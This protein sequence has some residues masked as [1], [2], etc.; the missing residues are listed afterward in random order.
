MLIKHVKI[1]LLLT[2]HDGSRH[3]GGKSFKTLKRNI[4]QSRSP[5][6]GKDGISLPSSLSSQCGP[7]LYGTPSVPLLRL[8][9]RLH[10]NFGS[11]VGIQVFGWTDSTITLFT[12]WGTLDFPLFFF[13]SAVLLRKSLRLS[14]VKR[15]D[16]VLNPGVRHPLHG[17]GSVH[18]MSASPISSPELVVH[19]LLPCW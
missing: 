18:P 4:R 14:V 17:G 9:R 10:L 3:K 13:P 5:S 7:A 8:R 2:V 12:L 15:P 16:F 1:T 11:F 19:S 6:I